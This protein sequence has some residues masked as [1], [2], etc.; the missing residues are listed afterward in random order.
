MLSYSIVFDIGPPRALIHYQR[1]VD[2]ALLGS[3]IIRTGK[4]KNELSQYDFTYYCI[5]E[6]PLNQN[7]SSNIREKLFGATVPPNKT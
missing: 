3:T 6:A 4:Q 1:F 7:P 5:K 2:L